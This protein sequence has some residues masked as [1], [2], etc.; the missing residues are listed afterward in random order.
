[1]KYEERKFRPVAVD[2]AIIHEGKIALVKRQQ[3]PFK[4]EWVLPGGYVETNETVEAA[5]VREAK[6]ETGL[7]VEIL[8]ILGVYS[9]PNRDERHNVSIAFIAFPKD[10]KTKIRKGEIKEVKWFDLDDIPRLGFD[11]EK[12]VKDAIEFYNGLQCN[13]CVHCSGCDF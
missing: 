2:I 5:A 3:E 4:G 10:T 11:H 1:M 13:N 6:E 9:D 7:D 8:G 12:I